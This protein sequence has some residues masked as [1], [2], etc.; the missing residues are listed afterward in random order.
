M[1]C[2]GGF[3]I[4]LCALS[5]GRTVEESGL[6]ELW[7][8]DLCCS[9]TFSLIIKMESTSIEVFMHIRPHLKWYLTCDLQNSFQKGLKFI[10]HWKLAQISY[11]KQRVVLQGCKR[12]AFLFY[13]L[14]LRRSTLK[15][16]YKTLMT[17][18]CIFQCT[19]GHA[20]T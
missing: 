3:R 2:P 6:D 11:Y 10:K 7:T 8:N 5:L 16:N 20:C 13:Y 14:S 12:H 17:A 9:E 4:A 18:S 19:S 1:L 15:S